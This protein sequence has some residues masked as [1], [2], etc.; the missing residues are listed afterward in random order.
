MTGDRLQVTVTDGSAGGPIRSHRDLVVWQKAMDLVVAIYRLAE[1]F[2][3]A[4]DFRLTRTLFYETGVE[5]IE[6]AG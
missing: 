2:P 6:V 3:R 4:E 1:R 5:V